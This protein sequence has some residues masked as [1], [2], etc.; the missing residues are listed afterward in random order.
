[1]FNFFHLVNNSLI[2]CTYSTEPL[3]ALGLPGGRYITL[4]QEE[5]VPLDAEE[6]N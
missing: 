5:K 3:Q 6:K 1:L 2:F 4:H